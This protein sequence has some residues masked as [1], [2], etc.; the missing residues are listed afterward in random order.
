MKQEVPLGRASRLLAPRPVCLLTTH[1]RG[2]DNVMTIGWV[3]AIS[4]EPPLVA[5]AMHPSR[6]T[7]DLLRRSEEF[8]LNVPGRRLAEVV[9]RCGTISGA[10][11]DKFALL[12]LEREAGRRVESPWIVDC[13]AHIECAL[14][15]LAQPGDHTLFI[16]R[17]VGA[18]AED[19]AFGE[20]WCGPDVD[21]ELQPLCHLGGQ[22]FVTLGRTFVQ[23]PP[24]TSD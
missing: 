3:G 23:A 9:V 5:V 7:H 2:R 13:L 14:E 19:E 8:T 4:L 20:T 24:E 1:Y 10:D 15:T 18:W 17:I 21:E 12:R 16:G 22:T 6:Y 11:E